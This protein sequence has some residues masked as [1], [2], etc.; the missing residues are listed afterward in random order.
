MYY[1][2]IFLNFEEDRRSLDMKICEQNVEVTLPIY[3]REKTFTKQELITILEDYFS[4][5]GTNQEFFTK[6]EE[7]LEEVKWF[8]VN[9]QTLQKN[10]FWRKRKDREQEKVRKLIVE[11][12]KEV[13][14][15]PWRYGRKFKIMIPQ[16]NSEYQTVAE[17][18][19]IAAEL[20]GHT[21]DWVEQ[22]LVWAQKI[23]DG[24]SWEK[25]CNLPDTATA[26]RVI[27]WKNGKARLVGSANH[28]HNC[29]PPAE[30]FGKDFSISDKCPSSVPLIVS[31]M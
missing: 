1:E 14:K 9:P 20:G 26:Y 31:Y 21:A 19:Q 3:G 17:L 18:Y 23:N 24:E 12:F 2:K 13:N 11:A 29:I 10:L 30:I 6:N 15:K 27:V 7:K 28:N 22:A 8:V 25:I 5:Q 16:K 4:E